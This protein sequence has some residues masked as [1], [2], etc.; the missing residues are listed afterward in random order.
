MSMKRNV[1]WKASAVGG[2]LLGSAI[3]FSAAAACF[4][5]LAGRAA[6]QTP[7][8][9]GTGASSKAQLDPSSGKF[10]DLIVEVTQAGKGV[11][12]AYKVRNVG[13]AQAGPSI[14]KIAVALLPLDSESKGRLT[15]KPINL[16]EL[17]KPPLQSLITKIDPI[18]PGES[19]TFYPQGLFPALKSLSALIGEQRRQWPAQPEFSYLVPCELEAVCVFRV[20]VTADDAGWVKEGPKEES[21]KN[22]SVTV[23]VERKT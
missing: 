19:K 8:P 13:T 6:A 9:F 15:L 21:E 22:N 23:Y 14:L 12:T 5:L 2:A 20:K 11:P 17:C 3:R 10:P 7:V 18:Q 4:L 16:N 1:A